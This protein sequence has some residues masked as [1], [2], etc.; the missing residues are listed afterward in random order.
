MRRSSLEVGIP[1]ATVRPRRS[2]TVRMPE[3]VRAMMELVTSWSVSRIASVRQAPPL[4][5]RLWTWAIGAF[6]AMS[7]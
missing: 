3:L 5:I 2:S 1:T 7:T 4:V 6:Q